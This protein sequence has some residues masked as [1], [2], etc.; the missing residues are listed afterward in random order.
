MKTDLKIVIKSSKAAQASEALYAHAFALGADIYFGPGEYN[1][2]SPETDRLLAHALTHV[3]QYDQGRLPQK[4][5]DSG[6]SNPS[7]PA[8]QEAYGNEDRIVGK[9]RVADASIAEGQSEATTTGSQSSSVE[10]IVSPP[11]S[12][13]TGDTSYT[14]HAGLDSEAGLESAGGESEGRTFGPAIEA[15][16]AASPGA[17]A[18]TV[19]LDHRH[20]PRHGRIVVG[21]WACARVRSFLGDS[22]RLPWWW[23]NCRSPLGIRW[24]GIS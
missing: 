7:D 20:P 21:G 23:G 6:V 24:P 1:P 12:A 3:L 8:E 16:R 17:T 4:T 5:G 14:D 2:G 19:T 11:A 10:S 9:L 18:G 15:A 22:S 13:D